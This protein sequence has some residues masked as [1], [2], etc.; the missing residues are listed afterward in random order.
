[1]L[2]REHRKFLFLWKRSS[3]DAVKFVLPENV[4]STPTFVIAIIYLWNSAFQCVYCLWN[5]RKLFNFCWAFGNCKMR[6]TTYNNFWLALVSTV[7]IS[8]SHV[9]LLLCFASKKE[10][11]KWRNL[12]LFWF[13]LF[14]AWIILKIWYLIK[15]FLYKLV[16][17]EREISFHVHYTFTQTWKQQTPATRNN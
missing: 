13:C 16:G 15:F 9:V 12:K 11:T 6:N 1:M 17:R 4:A 5:W 8:S 14:H 2:K 3:K 7:F 10:E